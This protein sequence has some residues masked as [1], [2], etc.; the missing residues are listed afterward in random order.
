MHK[1]QGAEMVLWYILRYFKQIIQN[2]DCSF[3]EI[4]E[5]HTLNRKGIQTLLEYSNI[6]LKS[7]NAGPLNEYPF[8]TSF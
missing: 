5:F 2:F 7:K 6:V 1:L 4:L 3:E 8:L